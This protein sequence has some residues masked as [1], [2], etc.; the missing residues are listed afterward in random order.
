MSELWQLFQAG[1]VMMY[2][3]LLSSIAAVAITVERVMVYR[4][5]RPQMS[6]GAGFEALLREGQLDEATHW[7]ERA[8]GLT[9]RLASEALRS[10]YRGNALREWLEM[11]AQY[12]TGQL[13]ARLNMLSAVVTLAPLMGLL[14]T[15]TGMIHS[16]NVLN[17]AQGE[18][19]AITGGVAEALIATAFGLLVAILAMGAWVCLSQSAS[20][21]IDELERVCGMLLVGLESSRSEDTTRTSDVKS[22]APARENLRGVNTLTPTTSQEETQATHTDSAGQHLAPMHP[23][24]HTLEAG[25]LVFVK[26]KVAAPL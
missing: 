21:L 10:G 22:E 20:R 12:R 2:A 5:A 3:L 8:G 24:P 9:G 26:K 19:F 11:Q 13:R 6:F 23:A 7:A 15:V 17:V 16:F 14:G 25:N 4:R 18:P 1:G